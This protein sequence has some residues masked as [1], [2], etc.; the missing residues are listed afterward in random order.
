MSGTRPWRRVVATAGALGMAVM[1]ATPASAQTAS[2]SVSDPI[3]S[4]LIGP[5]G[6]AVTDNGAIYVAESFAGRLTRVLPNG[7][8]TALYQAE[9]SSPNGVAISFAGRVVMTL[10]IF[11]EDPN[12]PPEDTTLVEVR[13]NGATNTLASLQDHEEA[14]NPDGGETYGFENLPA[15]CEA[16]LPPELLPYSGIVESNPYKVATLGPFSFAVADA[17]GNSIVR[18]DL[19]RTSTVAVLPP[20]PQRITFG[21]IRQLGLPLCTV[22]RNY[23]SEPVPTDV[24][25]G[26]D[27]QWYVSALPGRPELPGYGSVYRVN[28]E[29]GDVSLVTRGFSGAVDLAVADDGTIYV[30]E[31]FANK[32][33]SISNGVVAPVV[34]VFAPGAV[35]ITSDGTIYATTGVFGPAGDVVIVTP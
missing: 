22:G 17:A 27:G 30:A 21:N 3:V 26:P 5:L 2:G 20:I 24:E 32:I 12:G 13:P 29:N 18:V 31:L 4:G 33:S 8:R 11:P 1:M 23:T 19:G 9:G 10:S 7:Y 34:D 28:P 16:K 15:G 6:L 25:V 14:T 35:E